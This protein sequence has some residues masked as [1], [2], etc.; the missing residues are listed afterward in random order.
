MSWERKLFTEAQ[1]PGKPGELDWRLETGVFV[2][3]FIYF[4]FTFFIARRIS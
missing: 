3:I 2:I 4:W 1:S